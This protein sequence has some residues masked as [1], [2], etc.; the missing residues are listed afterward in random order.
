M[1]L[2]TD[3]PVGFQVNAPPPHTQEWSDRYFFY[4][5]PYWHVSRPH[6]P[7]ILSSAELWWMPGVVLNH[8]FLSNKVLYL[9]FVTL[10]FRLALVTMMT[11]LLGVGYR[12]SLTHGNAI[13]RL[14]ILGIPLLFMLS[15]TS[16]IA[17]MNSFYREYPAFLSLI[18]LFLSFLWLGEKATPLRFLVFT[19]FLASLAANR[20]SYV[21]WIVLAPL[22]LL[23]SWK[24]QRR[25][26]WLIPLSLF[27]TLPP[28]LM[29]GLHIPNWLLTAYR[30]NSLFD[31]ALY[32]SRQ[33]E[34]HL[35][36]LKLDSYSFCI[37]QNFPPLPHYK[38]CYPKLKDHVRFTH[39]LSVYFHEPSALVR[40]MVYAL[41]SL[42]NI[43]PP[44]PIHSKADPIRSS[45][46]RITYTWSRLTQWIYPQGIGMVLFLFAQA[47]LLLTGL[48]QNEKSIRRISLLGLLSWFGIFTDCF[49]TLLGNGKTEMQRTLFLSH[50]LLDITTLI[51]IFVFFEILVEF[52]RTRGFTNLKTSS[53]IVGP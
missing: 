36:R 35:Q 23:F 29:C 47:L 14:W 26:F 37:G 4:Y 25:K 38:E 1:V 46:R 42:Q 33:P 19:S 6:I 34:Q 12:R 27:L 7:V 24:G 30:Y 22:F 20:L 49:V 11:C 32:F 45:Q 52:A 16:S 53:E 50:A 39:V 44:F 31:G 15:D 43:Q 9:P 48:L 2:F 40:G 51:T 3:K 21:Y 10:P 5:L 41:D 8:I 18:G 28:S 13:L 17:Y